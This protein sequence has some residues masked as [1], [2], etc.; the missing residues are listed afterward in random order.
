[1]CLQS[2]DGLRE[3]LWCPALVGGSHIPRAW[4]YSL[5]CLFFPSDIWVLLYVM[6]P[7]LI[8]A[9]LQ[10]FAVS[11]DSQF[12]NNFFSQIGM[13]CLG[14][15]ELPGMFLLVDFRCC[16]GVFLLF[17]L[18]MASEWTI[19]LVLFSAVIGCCRRRAIALSIFLCQ[20]TRLLHTWSEYLRATFSCLLLCAPLFNTQL[21]GLETSQ[22]VP[23]SYWQTWPRLQMSTQG[24]KVSH[25]AHT[26]LERIFHATWWS[27]WQPC[28][29]TVGRESRGLLAEEG[30][31]CGTNS[32]NYL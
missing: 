16:A 3:L 15:W 20:C 25:C 32:C 24:V 6:F 21:Y 1:M 23:L 10:N 7:V 11:A 9:V 26:Y 28:C 27:H 14:S 29:A 12:W 18:L 13:A 5:S 31:G 8:Q 22:E 2:G 30:S 19:C 17:S 4:I